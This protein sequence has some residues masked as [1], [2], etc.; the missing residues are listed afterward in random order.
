MKDLLVA[1]GAPHEV[2]EC[3]QSRMHK[4]RYVPKVLASQTFM[5]SMEMFG[6]FGV[7]SQCG[8]S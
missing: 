3:L 7:I 5:K 4:T 6:A 1:R 8:S 2:E